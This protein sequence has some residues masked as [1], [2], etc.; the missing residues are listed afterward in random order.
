MQ[1]KAQTVRLSVLQRQATCDILTASHIIVN[2]RI[3]YCKTRRYLNK[4]AVVIQCHRNADTSLRELLQ[5]LS[6]K[7]LCRLCKA[8]E[9]Q[10]NSK[11]RWY[12]EPKMTWTSSWM[13]RIKHFSRCAMS[14]TNHNA[15]CAGKGRC[16]ELA[17]WTRQFQ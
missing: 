9:D 3:V 6:Q 7:Q 16:G 4:F 2:R 11:A 8:L 15:A 14:S 12:V 1:Q 10:V 13:L 5:S 17:C